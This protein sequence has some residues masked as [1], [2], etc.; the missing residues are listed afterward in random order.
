[1]SDEKQATPYGCVTK[2]FGYV[3]MS[4]DVEDQAIHDL[5]ATLI[6]DGYELPPRECC[7][8]PDDASNDIVIT[9]AYGSCDVLYCRCGR[10]TE[11]GWGPIGCRCQLEAPAHWRVFERK[12]ISVKKVAL[13]I[14][15]KRA[16]QGRG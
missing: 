6:T 1:M 3:E 10:N 4:P 7:G 13:P 14:T 9:C 15:K 12:M 8:A 5:F 2:G 11:A 16:R